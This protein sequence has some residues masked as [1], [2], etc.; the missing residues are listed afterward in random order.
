MPVRPL[1]STTI[2]LFYSTG[3][4]VIQDLRK[5]SGLT[6]YLAFDTQCYPYKYSL[7]VSPIIIENDF[8][9]YFHKRF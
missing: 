7:C 1:I 8:N 9:P 5:L 3:I 6:L 4:R 2:I